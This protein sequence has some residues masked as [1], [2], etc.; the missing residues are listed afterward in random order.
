MDM[1]HLAG[2]SLFLVAQCWWLFTSH[3]RMIR[4]VDETKES[5]SSEWNRAWAWY[6]ASASIRKAV[7]S[8]IAKT[9]PDFGNAVD[10]YMT[11]KESISFNIPNVKFKFHLCSLLPPRADWWYFIFS[12]PGQC[13]W[14]F[15]ATNGKYSK[16]VHTLSRNFSIT[17]CHKPPMNKNPLA[18]RGLVTLI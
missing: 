16:I 18:F 15:I 17:R 9:L 8:F 5:M 11:I 6:I 3:F 1:V 4:A 14:N 12:I 10:G 2:T 13:A 7:S